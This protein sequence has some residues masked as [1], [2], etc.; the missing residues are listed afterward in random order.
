M[1]RR[2]TVRSCPNPQCD[3]PE[4]SCN[5]GWE[6]LCDC[7]MWVS[8]AGADRNGRVGPEADVDPG[9]EDKNLRLPWTGSTLGTRD[10]EFVAARSQPRVVGLVGAHN[11]GKTTFL[12]MTYLVLSRGHSVA[13][14]AFSG[15]YSL[16]GW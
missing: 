11:S 5:D 8:G 1:E 15:S 4:V 7:P 6:Q 16:G 10:L 9:L 12:G 13:N 2:R 14:A 3:A